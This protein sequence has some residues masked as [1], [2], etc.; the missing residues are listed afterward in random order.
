VGN[1]LNLTNYPSNNSSPNDLK[2]EFEE[3]NSQAN[4]ELLQYTHVPLK[5]SQNLTIMDVY[6]PEKEPASSKHWVHKIG[7]IYAS[8][9][10][11]MLPSNLKPIH[12]QLDVSFRNI[13]R[14]ISFYSSI[15]RNSSQ[16]N[17]YMVLLKSLLSHLKTLLQTKSSFMPRRI[18]LLNVSN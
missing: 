8:E 5:P 11:S 1:L 10:L 3:E 18:S 14:L 13:V 15:L 7:A 16:R 12:Y 4:D 2:V 6:P 9:P 17:I